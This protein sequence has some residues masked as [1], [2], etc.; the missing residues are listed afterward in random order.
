MMKQQK[1]AE[2]KI[3]EPEL[4]TKFIFSTLANAGNKLV[5]FFD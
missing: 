5:E 4:G 2:K 1:Q 3:Y